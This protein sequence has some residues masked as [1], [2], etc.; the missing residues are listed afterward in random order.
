MLKY[1]LIALVG[2]SSVMFSAQPAE[3]HFPIARKAVRVT[4]H[5]VRVPL[6]IVVTPVK[7]VVRP[8]AARRARSCR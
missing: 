5:V 2:I 7:A 8:F 4:A 3:A 1:C 6:R